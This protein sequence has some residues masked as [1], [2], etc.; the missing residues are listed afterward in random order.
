[1]PRI[2]PRLAQWRLV[3]ILTASIA[4][5]FGAGV[6]T[7]AA[8]PL[9]PEGVFEN[10]AL[11]T[12]MSTCVQRLQA[13]HQG[14]IQVVLIT[15]WSG[16]LD[17]LS[18]YAQA[19]HSMGMSVMWELSNPI[20]WQ[21]PASGTQIDGYVSGF[22]TACGCTQNGAVLDYMISWL[23][24][25]PGTYGYYAADDSML[26]PGDRDGVAAFVSRIK[27]DDP[28]HTVMIGSGDARQ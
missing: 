15:A 11:D 9:P 21:S 19:A 5:L 25:L 22:A 18:T 12:Q 3:L 8:N 23:A 1:M 7:A 10:C 28:V 26:G 2:S 6:G 17:S 16:S 14:G 4:C 13:M 20:W 27:R 24:Q